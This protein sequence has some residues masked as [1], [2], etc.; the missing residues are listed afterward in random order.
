MLSSR[1]KQIVGRI[2]FGVVGFLD[3]VA[4]WIW[5]SIFGQVSNLI[6]SMV[7][8]SIANCIEALFLIFVLNFIKHDTL[9]QNSFSTLF[10]VSL[11]IGNLVTYSIA[12]FALGST[13]SQAVGLNSTA[14]IAVTLAFVQVFFRVFTFLG[15]R[16]LAAV[17]SITLFRMKD[18]NKPA[19]ESKVPIIIDDD[20]PLDG[21]MIE[22][23]RR[24]KAKQSPT[25]G[26]VTTLSLESNTDDAATTS[27]S[28]SKKKGLIIFGMAVVLDVAIFAILA[29]TS[30]QA[31]NL[32][33]AMTIASVLACIQFVILIAG[34]FLVRAMTSDLFSAVVLTLTLLV[35]LIL[36]ALT[37]AV[38]LAV[39]FEVMPWTLDLAVGVVITLASI[40]AI[41][42][43]LTFAF[44][45]GFSA[46]KFIFGVIV[47]IW[48]VIKSKLQLMM[49]KV[50]TEHEIQS[51]QTEI[52]SSLREFQEKVEAVTLGIPSSGTSVDESDVIAENRDIIATIDLQPVSDEASDEW[53]EDE[54]KAKSE[55][56]N[57]AVQ[58]IKCI[59]QVI[60]MHII[61]I[62][63]KFEV[64]AMV[65]SVLNPQIPT[66]PHTTAILSD[67]SAILSL[68][69]SIAIPCIGVTI[70]LVVPLWAG[71]ARFRSA[72]LALTF[73]VH[74]INISLTTLL[75]H[76]HIVLAL[77]L[78]FVRAV[79]DTGKFEATMKKEK[80]G[81]QKEYGTFASDQETKK[82]LLQDE[83]LQA[84]DEII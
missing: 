62:K 20:K 16:G 45:G 5:V 69:K 79:G 64:R 68:V 75:L 27:L 55:N 61:L 1:W 48:R 70:S 58:M 73:F 77:A 67:L 14:G 18:R 15:M 43:M 49:Q 12:V 13:L 33:I 34:L 83:G 81:K 65:Q 74:L 2:V 21:S 54:P 80:K 35:T 63:A 9:N 52:E 38:Y 41:P 4:V 32:D 22:L 72:F 23:E 37:M 71:D 59:V 56:A 8:L 6:V 3:L 42:L 17:N 82:P 66:D 46:V 50:N 51:L 53:I 19:E 47:E 31:S 44:F 76:A 39:S 36:H 7:S 26:V 28:K 29:L 57:V 30:Q 40:E 25:N 78:A 11:L 10:P 24:G 60:A 84:E